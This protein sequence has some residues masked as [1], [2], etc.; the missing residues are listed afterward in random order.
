MKI[1]DLLNKSQSELKDLIISLKKE[2]LNLKFQRV[3]G[4]L[5][6]PARFK[7]A[8]RD[9]ARIKTILNNQKNKD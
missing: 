8:R 2:K 7:I 3:N 6:N 5:T 4:Q 1:I 9:V